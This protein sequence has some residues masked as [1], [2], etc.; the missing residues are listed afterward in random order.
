ML[1]NARNYSLFSEPCEFP[2]LYLGH[3]LIGIEAGNWYHRKVDPGEAIRVDARGYTSSST[4][5][6]C[7]A[8]SHRRIHARHS[9]EEVLAS[10]RIA[11]SVQHFAPIRSSPIRLE[12][13]AH[14][15]R[16]GGSP[17]P[18]KTRVP[19]SQVI[20]VNDAAYVFD[21]GSAS[22]RSWLASKYA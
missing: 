11:V 18:R 15:A 6:E 19:S 14:S 13:A 1:G 4:L 17:R 9:A 12:N 16:H 20:L 5:P 21:C 22:L 8:S 2:R 7:Y 10:I 3:G